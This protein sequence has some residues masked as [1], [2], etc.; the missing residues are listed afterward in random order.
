LVD[1][2]RAEARLRRLEETLER[3]DAVR[4][5]GEDVYLAD[6]ELRAMTERWLQVAIQVCIDLGTQI[7]MEQSARAP[8]DYADIFKVLGQKGASATSLSTSTWRSTTAPCSPPSTIS[9]TCAS[10][11]P[12]FSGS[13]LSD[14]NDP[15][16]SGCNVFSV[17][18]ADNALH[19]GGYGLK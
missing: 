7:V 10:S 5:R 14:G 3:L 11:P 12:S 4:A 18:W 19:Q 9:T 13:S 17:L 15:N 16:L 1:A 2:D 6:P 8:S